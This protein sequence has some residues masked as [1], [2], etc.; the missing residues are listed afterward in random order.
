M[1]LFLCFISAIASLPAL[2][3]DKS[4]VDFTLAYSIIPKNNCDKIELITVLPQNIYKKQS[5]LDFQSFPQP[6][7]VY[8][9]GENNYAHFTFQ[10]LAT[11]QQIII[12]GKA[13]VY[14]YDIGKNLRK[15]NTILADYK[16]PDSLQDFIKPARYIESDDSEIIKEGM[17]LRDKY[18][19]GTI[20]NI[21]KF[22]QQTI[23]YKP[24]QMPMGAKFALTKKEG[25]CNEY[26]YLFAA[27][28]RVNGIPVKTAS[29]I[30]SWSRDPKIGHAWAE[31][32]ITG[33]GWITFDPIQKVDA[34]HYLHGQYLYLT[35]L[36]RDKELHN[37]HRYYVKTKCS[38]ADYETTWFAK[39]K[40]E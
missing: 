20:K 27:L 3:Q 33:L 18:L 15:E 14:N 7:S 35:S 34:L 24:Y 37:K 22:V 38:S 8:H 39:I 10:N 1:K 11:T 16:V 26:S 21:Y 31:V 6:D 32:F 12:T 28:C 19:M 13:L 40:V 25:D 17:A 9:V 5:V 2:C 30:V 4:I 23:T 29:G 36:E